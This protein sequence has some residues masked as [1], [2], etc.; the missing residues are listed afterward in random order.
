MKPRRPSAIAIATAVFIIIA[1][2]AAGMIT[3]MMSTRRAIDFPTN[4]EDSFFAIEKANS[5]LQSADSTTTLQQLCERAYAYLDSNDIV[6]KC[7]SVPTTLA[8]A[9]NENCDLN[10]ADWTDCND[11]SFLLPSSCVDD[12]AD[13]DEDNYYFK[14]NVSSF[15]DTK[16]TFSFKINCKGQTL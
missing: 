14:Y 13:S 1:V 4:R 5:L 7:A 10:S 6:G 3:I 9:V 12:D 11:I 16:Y 2:I 8:L 15:E